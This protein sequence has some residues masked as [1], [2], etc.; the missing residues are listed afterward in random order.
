MTM[1]AKSIKREIT[2]I[3]KSKRR[4]LNVIVP[5]ELAYDLNEYCADSGYSKTQVLISALRQYLAIKEEEH[6]F[7][8]AHPQRRVKSRVILE[9][10]PVENE[11][12]KM[13]SVLI[14]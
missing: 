2:R 4:A 3:G 9:A 10:L 14:Y 12:Q 11:T 6:F 8:L 1:E 5:D 7:K 13:A